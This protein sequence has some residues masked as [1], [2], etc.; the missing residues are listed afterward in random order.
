M[1]HSFAR[2]NDRVL[3]LFHQDTP[4]TARQCEEDVRR[5]ASRFGWRTVATP[6]RMDLIVRLLAG[7]WDGDAFV[8]VPPGCA[9]QLTVA[10]DGA[11]EPRG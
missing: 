10:A 3:V 6:V 1:E 2:N 8:V 7:Q 5:H 9:V 11:I 4:E